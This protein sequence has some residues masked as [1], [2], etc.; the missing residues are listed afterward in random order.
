[1]TSPVRQLPKPLLIHS[2]ATSGWA[3]RVHSRIYAF[4]SLIISDDSD[5]VIEDG[6]GRHRLDLLMYAPEIGIGL[7]WCREELHGDLVPLAIAGSEQETWM[8][9]AF[10]P[11]GIWVPIRGELSGQPYWTCTDQGELFGFY[12]HSPSHKQSTKL[13]DWLTPGLIRSWDQGA[14]ANVWM[15]M[16][17]GIL[18]ATVDRTRICPAC[19]QQMLPGVKRLP[20]L[21]PTVRT[22]EAVIRRMGVDP[23]LSRIGPMAW[24]LRLGS[25]EMVL[26]YA[27]EEASLCVDVHL[28]RIGPETARKDLCTYLLRENTRLESFGFSIQDD[29]VMI[30]LVL[31]DR[32]IQE[33]ETAGLL[34]DLLKKSDDYDNHL[35]SVFQALWL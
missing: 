34:V 33:I 24:M 13:S 22:L 17:C 1:M 8:Y 35:V 3:W 23:V 7:A 31:P 14:M 26:R 29:Q 32:A 12:P 11:I 19:G 25:A 20:G 27:P 28:V 2:M 16:P 18:E 9:P 15:C 30:S 21:S 4:P 10:P 6:S 5:L